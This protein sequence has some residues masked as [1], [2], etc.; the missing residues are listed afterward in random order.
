V[1]VWLVVQRA[2]L[3]PGF[4]DSLCAYGAIPAEMTG[5]GTL[6][7]DPRLPCRAG[8]LV[9]SAALTS[10]FL[11]GG[12]LHLIGNLWFLWV[13]GNNIEDSMGPGR[14]AVF[15]LVTGLGAT[16]AHVLTAWSSPVPVVGASGAISGVMGAY[17]VLYPHVRVI[18]AIVL[19]F[20][21]RIVAL[22]AGV[23]LGFWFVLQLL[24]GTAA[25]PAGAGVAF[26]AHVGGFVV[27]AVLVR[28]FAR[29][30]RVRRHRRTRL[31]SVDRDGFDVHE[32]F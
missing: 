31:V 25:G 29:P 8:G 6:G 9:W 11:H 3:G 20:F 2:G 22:P 30:A 19:F 10:M 26:W 12:W 14:F 23:L 5:A 27:G 17:I 15:Y 7:A 18:T 16:A 13:F 1:L 21:V 4:L 24:Q 32:R 28:A